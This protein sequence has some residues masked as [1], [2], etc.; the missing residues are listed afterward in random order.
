MQKVLQRTYKYAE[1]KSQ[2]L[3]IEVTPQMKE[4]KLVQS[5]DDIRKPTRSIEA[6]IL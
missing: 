4:L 1:E 6:T 5:L 3:G 2:H